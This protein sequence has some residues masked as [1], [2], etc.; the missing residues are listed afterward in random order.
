ME[1]WQSPGVPRSSLWSTGSSAQKLKLVIK[2]AQPNLRWGYTKSRDVPRTGLSAYSGAT[3][4]P[5]PAAWVGVTVKVPGR[6]A[7]GWPA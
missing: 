4:A 6:P 1:V 3:W 2:L 7:L 5:V